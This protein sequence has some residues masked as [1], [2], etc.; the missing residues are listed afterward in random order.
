MNNNLQVTN[1][2]KLY[3]SDFDLY[4]ENLCNKKT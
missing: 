1:Q 2:D 3:N 4:L